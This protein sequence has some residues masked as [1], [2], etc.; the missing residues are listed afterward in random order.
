MMKMDFDQ[1]EIMDFMGGLQKD[2]KDEMDALM[3]D[4]TSAVYEFGRNYVS[5]ELSTTRDFYLSNFKKRK[6]KKG[7]YIITLADK[8]AHLENG[9]AGF[10]L[11][12][13][14]LKG[15]EYRVIPIS[16]FEATDSGIKQVIKA[17][18]YKTQKLAK[19]KAQLM[20][21]AQ[22]SQVRSLLQRHSLYKT[23]THPSV[24]TQSATSKNPRKRAGGSPKTGYVGRLPTIPH[25]APFSK[26]I[27]PGLANISKYQFVQERESYVRTAEGGLEKGQMPFSRA[28]YVVFRTISRKHP[29]RPHPGFSG[30]HAFDKMAEFL[31]ANSGD[32]LLNK[33]LK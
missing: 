17:Y 5:G 18:G 7:E 14:L 10:D 6:V 20:R 16:I 25:T 9:Y 23:K 32:R 33:I 28:R 31:T 27:N 8:A 15:R 19:D 2:M 22:S 1:K 26:Q 4:M 3:D 24:T 21:T 29:W 13:A 12:T 30:V 11:T